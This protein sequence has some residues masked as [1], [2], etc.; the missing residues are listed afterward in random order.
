MNIINQIE[1]KT[2]ETLSS[3]S[4]TTQAKNLGTV[5]KTAADKFQSSASKLISSRGGKISTFG[6]AA[7][8]IALAGK[9]VLS[10]FG[11]F[12]P[13]YIDVK[14]KI[15]NSPSIGIDDLEEQCRQI[16][17]SRKSSAPVIPNMKRVM[18][19]VSKENVCSG[20]DFLEAAKNGHAVKTYNIED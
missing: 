2:V 15:K 12:N 6:A 4:K 5:A 8:L 14:E 3:A 16:S 20:E 7:A 10:L 18:A 19:A 17:L 9:Y 13:L 1:P 11:K